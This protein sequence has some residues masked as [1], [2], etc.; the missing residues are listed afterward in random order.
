MTTEYVSLVSRFSQ[1]SII[2]HLTVALIQPLNL[3]SSSR[4]LQ[5]AYNLICNSEWI[6]YIHTESYFFTVYIFAFNS[7]QWP[8]SCCYRHHDISQ[9]ISE[10]PQ[11][12]CRKQMASELFTITINNFCCCSVFFKAC[13]KR[14]HRSVEGKCRQQ[15]AINVWVC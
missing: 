12:V 15:L 14:W 3:H 1:P 13:V 8:Q 7:P 5:C 10:I 6:H 2:Q 11:R 4:G 9:L